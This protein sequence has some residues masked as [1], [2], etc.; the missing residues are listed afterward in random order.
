MLATH[1]PSKWCPWDKSGI[2]AK[3]TGRPNSQIQADEYVDRTEMPPG[4]EGEGCG[5]EGGGCGREGEGCGR[6]ME[7][8]GNPGQRLT[9]AFIPQCLTGQEFQAENWCKKCQG[10]DPPQQTAPIL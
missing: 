6:G 2:A 3:E 10:L 7:V 1:Q 4:R 5:R 9:R 8:A